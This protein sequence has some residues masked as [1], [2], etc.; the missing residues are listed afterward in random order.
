[1]H[2]NRYDQIKHYIGNGVD[3]KWVSTGYAYTKYAILNNEP[4]LSDEDLAII[5]DKGNLPFGF[6]REGN[7]IFVYTD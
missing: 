6:R 2:R 3:V 5:C 1:M 4:G 7:M